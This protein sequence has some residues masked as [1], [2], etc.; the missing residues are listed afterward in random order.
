MASSKAQI[1]GD[2]PSLDWRFPIKLPNLPA[3][4]LQAVPSRRQF[5]KRTC[6]QEIDSHQW[7]SALKAGLS[8]ETL[9][10]SGWRFNCPQPKKQ[11]G[12]KDHL[13]GTLET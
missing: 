8:P 13:G 2:H 10:F 12:R 1:E 9:S 7:I 5:R 6:D 3:Y 4:Q 11:H